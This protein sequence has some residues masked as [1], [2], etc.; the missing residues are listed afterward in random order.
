MTPL[1]MKIAGV[2]GIPTMTSITDPTAIV[3]VTATIR[4]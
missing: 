3:A 4:S 1:L 2:R